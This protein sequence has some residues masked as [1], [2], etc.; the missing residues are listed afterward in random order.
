MI[1]ISIVIL[2]HAFVQP[3]TVELVSTESLPVVEVRLVVNITTEPTWI[4]ST[5]VTSVRLV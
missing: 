4:S 3:V 1:P 5:Q 2:T